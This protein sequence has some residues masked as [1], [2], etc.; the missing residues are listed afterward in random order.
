L[1]IFHF[2]INRE[3]RNGIRKLKIML[4]A[5]IIEYK[6]EFIMLFSKSI[7]IIIILVLNFT[8]SPIPSRID[9]FVP[10][11]FLPMI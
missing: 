10:S 1:F 9:F 8:E 11:S 3:K 2:S 5:T 4:E 6:F 7:F